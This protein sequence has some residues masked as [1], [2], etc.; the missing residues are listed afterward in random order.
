MGPAARVEASVERAIAWLYAWWGGPQAC[1]APPWPS[2][3]A[4]DGS[5]PCSLSHDAAWGTPNARPGRASG[6]D[7]REQGRLRAAREAEGRVLAGAQAG[8]HVQ[9]G[10][11]PA[12]QPADALAGQIAVGH[13]RPDPGEAH[14]PA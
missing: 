11:A 8:A 3:P 10:R 12:R 9:P 4:R 5:S 1:P 6:R 2:S 14:L 7:Q 13:Q